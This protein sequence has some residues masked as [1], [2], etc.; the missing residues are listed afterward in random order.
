MTISMPVEAHGIAV[1]LGGRRVLSGIDLELHDGELL[2][3]IGPNGSGKTTLLRTMLGLQPADEGEVKILGHPARELEAAA[4]ARRAAWMPQEERPSENLSVEEYVALARFPH[5]G[6]FGLEDESDRR[7][8]EEALLTC[9]LVGLRHRGILDVSGGERQRVLFARALAQASPVLVLDEPTSHL[10][11]ARQFE[12]MAYLDRFRRESPGRA[13]LIAMHDLN[14]ACRFA[15]RLLWLARGRVASIDTPRASVTAERVYQVFGVEA[16]VQS[17][18]GQVV[19]FPPRPTVRPPRPGRG[20]RRVHVICGGGS[21]EELL[22]AL[23][24]SGHSVSAGALHLLDSDEVLAREL[25]VSAAIEAPFSRLSDPIRAENR[26]LMSSAEVVVVAALC[27]GPGN[28]PNLEDLLALTGNRRIILLR[29][30][31]LSERD[32]TG[33]KGAQILAQL[34]ATGAESGIGIPALLKV[35]Q[36]RPPA[37][38]SEAISEHALL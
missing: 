18:E 27:I 5:I 13:V 21:G 3:V 19:V 11:M 35:L 4:R 16:V 32:F 15:D 20:S 10:D 29:G 24:E 23:V 37:G 6:A 36:E 34:E 30:R 2:A 31:P 12:V 9:D 25:H 33:G 38:G 14:L 26:Q 22:P 28:L 1:D 8:V 17:R 7:A